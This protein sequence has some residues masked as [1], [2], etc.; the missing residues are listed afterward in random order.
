MEEVKKL[1]AA[2][3][4]QYVKASAAYV[5]IVKAKDKAEAY[6]QA[7]TYDEEYDD[8]DDDDGDVDDALLLEMLGPTIEMADTLALAATAL[9][10]R[11]PDQSLA[12][13]VRIEIYKL[14]SRGLVDLDRL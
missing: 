1:S 12:L 8:D 7:D 11:E 3:L 13:E 10:I 6:A 4:E 2:Y 14:V 9:E 5:K